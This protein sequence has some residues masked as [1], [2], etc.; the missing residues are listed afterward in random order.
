MILTCAQVEN[1]C[2]RLETEK[3]G[4]VD[5]FVVLNWLFSSLLVFLISFSLKVGHTAQDKT[6]EVNTVL[7]GVEHSFPSAGPFA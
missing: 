6:S 4:S 5:S 1:Q 3:S 2:T 7:F